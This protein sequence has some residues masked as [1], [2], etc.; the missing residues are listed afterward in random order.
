MKKIIAAILFITCLC[1]GNVFSQTIQIIMTPK[2]SPYLAD[3]QSKTETITMIVNNTTGTAIDCKIKTQLYDGNGSLIGET[4][5]SKMPLISLS[6]GI[7]QFHA[8][9]I[10]PLPAINFYGGT[11]LKI[12][13]AQTGKLPEDNYKLC[14]SLMNPTT[15]VAINTLP[16]CKM[17]TLAAFQIPT[18]ISPRNDEE[19][20]ET[21]VRG[22]IFRWTAVIPS[23]NYIVTYKLQVWEVPNGTS[24]VTAIRT[25]QPIVDKD[26]RGQTQALWPVDFALPEVGKKYVWAITPIDDQGRKVCEGMG[27]SMPSGFSVMSMGQTRSDTFIPIKGKPKPTITLL[28]PIIEKNK[29]SVLVITFKWET[30]GEIDKTYAI[31][32]SEIKN[33]TTPEQA[34]QLKKDRDPHHGVPTHDI[35]LKTITIPLSELKYDSSKSYAWQ[36]SSGESKSGVGTF[37]GETRGITIPIL[38]K[39]MPGPSIAFISQESKVPGALA[40]K[41]LITNNDS[42]SINTPQGLKISLSKDSIIS[43]D[44]NLSKDWKRTPSKSPPGSNIVSWINNTRKIPTGETNL[45]NVQFGIPNTN[46]FYVAYEWLDKSGKT[47]YKDSVMLNINEA[48]P[49]LLGT[50]I[51]SKGKNPDSCKFKFRST[52]KI[53]NAREK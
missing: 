19:I 33:G 16:Q 22:I 48:E 35:L 13:L 50:F 8:D 25:T 32:I 44:D 34:M 18:L 28:K 29:D 9:D 2:P 46:S 24:G 6:P 39:P 26:Y 53:T 40:Y 38:G 31:N 21:N 30:N 4:S 23:P 47:M 11:Q 27:M 42:G 49:N 5:L 10:Y 17:F 12:E 52:E 45:G 41:L 1:S 3:W 7:N 14:V 37:K 43:I 15:G 51:I 36:V 20:L